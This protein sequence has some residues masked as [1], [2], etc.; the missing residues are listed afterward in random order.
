VEFV[1]KSDGHALLLA[2]FCDE[3]LNAAVHRNVV[4]VIY[5]ASV[6][7]VLIEIEKPKLLGEDSFFFLASSVYGV[8]PRFLVVFPLFAGHNQ[9]VWETG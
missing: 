2:L 4:A 7:E 9:Y 3:I 1:R 6:V 8:S 5:L